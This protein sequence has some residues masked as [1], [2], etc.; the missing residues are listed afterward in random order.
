MGNGF[1]KSGLKLLRIVL[2]KAIS[3]FNKPL[4]VYNKFNQCMIFFGILSN[5]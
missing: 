5:F 3:K 2:G 4:F 1:G